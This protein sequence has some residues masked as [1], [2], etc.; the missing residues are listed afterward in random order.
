MRIRKALETRWKITNF[1]YRVLLSPV[2][3][4]NFFLNGVSIANGASVFGVPLIQKHSNAVIT[5]GNN[6]SMRNGKRYNPISQNAC[7]VI[8][9]R[10]PSSRIVIGNNVG[11]SSSVIV[12]ADSI[13]IG[14]RVLIG[15]N[16]SIID[17]DFHPL[18]VEQRVSNPKSGLSRPISIG[19]DV[20]IGMNCIIL[21]GSII[22]DGSVIGAGSVV[23]GHIPPGSVAIGNPAKVVKTI[24]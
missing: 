22:G 2:N 17:T 4:V 19:N 10:E 8:S 16:T 12:G 21:K 20:F 18:S 14:D 3:K 5:I 6:F 7:C 13:D 1:L 15:A 9:A 24:N 11:M 23:S